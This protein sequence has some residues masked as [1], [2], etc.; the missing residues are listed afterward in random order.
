MTEKS[1]KE[2]VKS[3]W[4]ANVKKDEL[5]RKKMI[6]QKQDNNSILISDN[7]GKLYLMECEARELVEKLRVLLLGCE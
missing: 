5:E 1:L 4:K 7:V 3:D 6:V 2:W